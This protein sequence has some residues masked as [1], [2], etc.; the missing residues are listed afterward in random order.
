MLASKICVIPDIAHISSGVSTVYSISEH[1]HH[2]LHNNL[3]Q[4]F[5]LTLRAFVVLL[6]FT[7]LQQLQLCINA[8]IFAGCVGSF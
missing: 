7:F 8:S 5:D 3:T 2:G 4:S 1:L 6:L